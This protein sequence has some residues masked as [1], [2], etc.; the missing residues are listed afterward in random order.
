VPIQLTSE[1][2]AAHDR[3]EPFG[4]AQPRQWKMGWL[5][6]AEEEEVSQSTTY[7]GLLGESERFALDMVNPPL[8]QLSQLGWTKARTVAHVLA[9]L[10][11]KLDAHLIEEID[12]VQAEHVDAADDHDDGEE[13]DRDEEDE[14]DPGE[15]I[16]TMPESSGLVSET[17]HPWFTSSLMQEMKF[18]HA[19][20]S[21]SR[22]MVFGRSWRNSCYG[23]CLCW[24]SS[25][26]CLTPQPPPWNDYER[27]HNQAAR[28]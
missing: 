21:N 18:L 19:I 5:L 8:G 4:S 14:D 26:L 13:D 25:R 24:T 2:H 20:S 23:K 6:A 27:F 17:V 16:A 3:N 10:D 28:C 12:A 9:C 7:H 15:E 22:S 11:V 1:G